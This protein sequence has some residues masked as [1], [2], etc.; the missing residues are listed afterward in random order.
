M[1][2]AGGLLLAPEPTMLTK[3]GGVALG[4]YSADIT[5]SGPRQAW[6]GH[7]TET[8][9]YYA[10]AGVARELGAPEETAETI[11]RGVDIVVPIALS[12]GLAAARIAAIRGGRVALIEH[13]AAT[14]SRLGG[15]TILKPSVSPTR[16]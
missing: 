2:G 8:M 7:E 10:T 13:E 3:V 16:N 5:Q 11:A 15:H 14:G 9:T 1:I 4:A 12:G 6:T